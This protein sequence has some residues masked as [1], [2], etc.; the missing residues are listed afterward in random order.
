MIDF[1]VVRL[2]TCFLLL[3][4]VVYFFLLFALLYCV[5]AVTWMIDAQEYSS[6]VVGETSVGHFT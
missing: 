5:V 4:F 3:L 1:L 2:I 6:T